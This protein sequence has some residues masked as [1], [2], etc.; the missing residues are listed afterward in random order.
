MIVFD[1]RCTGGH[2]FEAWFGSSGDYEDQRGRGLVS[3]PMC[4]DAQVTKAPMSPAVPAKGGSHGT[5]A[6]AAMAAAPP[7]AVKEMLA[8]MA[9]LQKKI[10]AQAENVGPRFAE[11]ARAIHHKEAEERPI[12]GACSVGEA[13][14]LREEGIAVAPLPFPVVDPAKAN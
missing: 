5:P 13:E 9:E 3:C 12:Y 7:G 4:G 6:P 10:V 1:L 8:A 2:V 14:S 11:E